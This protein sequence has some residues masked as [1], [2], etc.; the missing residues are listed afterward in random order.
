VPS[1]DGIELLEAHH[2]AASLLDPMVVE[3]TLI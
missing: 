2:I 1:V 3:K